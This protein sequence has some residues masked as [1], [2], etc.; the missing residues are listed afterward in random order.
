MDILWEKT[1]K[2]IKEKISQ[3]NFETWISPIRID[4]L[5]GDQATLAVPNRFF[6]DWLVEN[7]LDVIRE[8]M[9]SAAGVRYNVEFLR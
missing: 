6:R 7:F 1:V 4:A 5:E 9:K 3:Q 2:I 8:A